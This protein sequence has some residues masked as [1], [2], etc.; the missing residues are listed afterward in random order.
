MSQT[1][2]Q[3]RTRY[4]RLKGQGCCIRCRSPHDVREGVCC[5]GCRDIKGE[6][7]RRRRKVG[8]GS[9]STQAERAVSTGRSAAQKTP[10][11]NQISV[12]S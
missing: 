5:A 10:S 8:S 1:P 7:G 9:V 6:E 4:Q 3:K 2:E 11:S 12:S